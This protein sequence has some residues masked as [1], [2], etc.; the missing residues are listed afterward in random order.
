MKNLI[1]ILNIKCVDNAGTTKEHVVYQDRLDRIESIRVNHGPE[2]RD[3]DFVLAVIV[4]E[5]KGVIVKFTNPQDAL[6]CYNAVKAAIL[7]P[8]GSITTVDLNA[9]NQI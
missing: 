9:F 3:E 1:E 2:E 6:S 5:S 4:C 8:E 7:A